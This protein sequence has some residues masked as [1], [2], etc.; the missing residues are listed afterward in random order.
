MSDREL[1][2]ISISTLVNSDSSREL[3]QNSISVLFQNLPI[4][5]SG[6]ITGSSNSTGNLNLI[7][8][9]Y[10]SISGSSNVSGSLFVSGSMTI[11]K[12]MIYST[13]F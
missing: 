4:Y 1:S 2:Q 8:Y 12:N 10:G 9:L 5:L 11:I 7:Q 6:S 13:A 3:S